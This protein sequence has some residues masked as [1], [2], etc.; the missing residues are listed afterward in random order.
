MEDYLLDFLKERFSTTAIA[1]EEWQT[2]EITNNA[3][4]LARTYEEKRDIGKSIGKTNHSLDK[5]IQVL[6]S[7]NNVPMRLV[8]LTPADLAKIPI[9]FYVISK[10]GSDE[11][12]GTIEWTVDNDGATAKIRKRIDDWNRENKK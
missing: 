8:S 5:A 12:L 4:E 3:D 6:R 9:V 2:S 7:L 11:I 1:S 10:V